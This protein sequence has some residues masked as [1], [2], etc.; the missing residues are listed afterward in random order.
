MEVRTTST[1]NKSSNV[2]LSIR[3][4]RSIP[5][6][7]DR[8]ITANWLKFKLFNQFAVIIRYQFNMYLRYILTPQIIIKASL[9]WGRYRYFVFVA[10]YL[11][12]RPRHQLINTNLWKKREIYF[13][14]FFGYVKCFYNLF[15]QY[16]EIKNWQRQKNKIFII[17]VSKFKPPSTSSVKIA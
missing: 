4:I 9:V 3:S 12:L 5:S 7:V 8:I 10:I 17:Y 1:N 16:N 14:N 11:L 2:C 15:Y 6:S 13:W